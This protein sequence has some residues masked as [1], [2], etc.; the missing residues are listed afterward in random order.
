MSNAGEQC[1]H[2]GKAS[3]MRRRLKLKDHTVGLWVDLVLGWRFVILR[4]C[5]V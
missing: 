5:N 1:Q 2:A 3:A 4:M